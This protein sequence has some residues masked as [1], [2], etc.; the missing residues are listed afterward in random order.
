MGLSA[1]MDLSE[2]IHRAACSTTGRNC[3]TMPLGS[4]SV[5]GR[6]SLMSISDH[7]AYRNCGQAHRRMRRSI[8]AIRT[9]NRPTCQNMAAVQSTTNGRWH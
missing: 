7:S 9:I 6:T 8:Q 3:G 2:S 5:G 1:A 4:D